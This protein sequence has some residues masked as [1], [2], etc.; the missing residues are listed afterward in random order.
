MQDD[1]EKLT[2]KEYV[3]VISDSKEVINVTPLAVKSPI[4]SWKSYCKEDVGYYEIH[5]ADRSYKTYMFFSEMLSD[6]DKEDLTVLYRLFNEKNA[7]TRPGFDDLMLWGDMKIMLE[8]DK[9]DLVWKNHHSQ[10]LIEWKLYDS[11]GVH[12]LMLT[13]VTIHMLVEKKYPLPQETLARMLRWN[14]HVNNDVTEMAY[15]FLR[16]IK[17]QLRQ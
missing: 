3:E 5:R 4:V 6:F 14:L 15:E 1:P 17:S 2:L 7:S 8:L 16:F 13:D 9:D 11:C 10:E 12:S